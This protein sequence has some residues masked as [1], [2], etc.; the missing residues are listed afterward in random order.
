MNVDCPR[1]RSSPAPMRVRMRSIGP[2][3]RA[4]RRH[5]A[6]DVRKQHDQRVLPHV[7]RLAA[8]VRAGDDEHAHVALAVAQSSTRSLGSKGSSRTASTTGW[9]PRSMWRPG[10]SPSSG[11][12]S[13]ALRPLGETGEHVELRERSGAALAA[14]RG[15]RSAASS[16]PS[17]SSFSRASERSRA[18]ST[19]SSNAFSSSRDVALGARQRLSPRVM[20]S[21]PCRPALAD[22]DVVAVHA[23]VADLQRRDAAGCAFARFQVDQE[24]IGVRRQHAQ[25]VERPRRSHRRSRRRR[26]RAPVAAARSRDASSCACAACSP[27]AAASAWRRGESSGRQRIAQIG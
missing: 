22:F 26:A 2:I 18:D 8:H 4:R 16:S 3:T 6:A 24:L 11:R 15:V 1:A 25:L 27:S 9:R 23:V 17:Y 12:A 14:A 7:G 13:Q 10:P 20:R 19:L 5:E 21:A